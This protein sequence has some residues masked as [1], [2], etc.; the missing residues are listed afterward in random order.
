MTSFQVAE[1]VALV[2]AVQFYSV[3]E[4]LQSVK[5]YLAVVVV[6]VKFGD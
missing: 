2:I 3:V 1:M 4:D 5:Y 6:A